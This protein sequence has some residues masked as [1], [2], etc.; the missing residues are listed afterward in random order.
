MGKPIILCLSE[1]VGKKSQDARGYFNLP[2]NNPGVQAFKQLE[3]AG[4]QEYL[5]EEKKFRKT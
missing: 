3:Q 1:I 2:D 4:V 5:T